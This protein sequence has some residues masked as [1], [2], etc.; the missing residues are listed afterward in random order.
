LRQ[1]GPPIWMGSWGSAAGLRRTARLGDG[2]LA[3]AYNTT[4][5][6][7]A[8]ARSRLEEHLRA[9]GKAPNRFPNAIATMFFH[10]TEDRAEADHIVLN[11]LAPM[12]RCPGEELRRHLLV[13]P[14]GECAGKLDAYRSAGVERII[15]WPVKDEL[16]Q[17]GAFREQVIPLAH[18][19]LGEE[20]G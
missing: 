17:L 9:A 13:G 5:E 14:A 3:S 20:P 19:S 2:W 15:L 11:L 10:V 6:A 4:P 12:L 16:R 1:P 7:F 8:D 18:A